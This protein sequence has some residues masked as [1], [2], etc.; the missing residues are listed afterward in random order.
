MVYPH[1]PMYL[2]KQLVACLMLQNEDMCADYFRTMVL[3]IDHM[4]QLGVMH[5]H[6]FPAFCEMLLKL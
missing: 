5:R 4:H 1:H 3:V 2:A 6:V